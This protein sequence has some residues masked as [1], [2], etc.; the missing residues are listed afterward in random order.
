[1]LGFV[2]FRGAS[3]PLLKRRSQLRRSKAELIDPNWTQARM[4]LRSNLS[5]DG[6]SARGSRKKAPEELSAKAGLLLFGPR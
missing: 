4:L 3:P 6:T 2:G 5:S 1:M